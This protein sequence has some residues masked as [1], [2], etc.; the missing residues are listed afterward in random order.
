[1]ESDLSFA[2]K[3]PYLSRDLSENPCIKSEIPTMIPSQLGSTISLPPSH[4]TT[5]LYQN[6]CNQFKEHP[7]NEANHHSS[8]P[9][10]A[11]SSISP[12]PMI[13]TPLYKVAH[14]NGSQREFLNSQNPMIFAP[15]YNKMEVMHGRLNSGKGIWDLSTKNLFHYGETSQPR[16][17]PDIIKG[18]WT[19]NEDRVLVQ[20]VNH[21]GLRKWSHIAKYMK[22]RIGKQCRE[23]WNNH[24]RPDIKKDSWTEEEDKILIKAHKT[25]GNK[26]AEISKRL[27]GR[28]ENSIKNH[29][30]AT[31]RRQNAKRKN[32]GNSSKGIL[33]L[34]YIMEVTNAKKAEKKLVKNSTSMTN[35][36]NQSNFESSESDFSSKDLA[37]PEEEIDGYVPMMDHHDDGMARGSGTTMSYEFGTYGMEFFHEVPMK[38]EI[39]LMNMI[40][41]NP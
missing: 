39:D 1:M 14:T 5:F 18:Q 40:Y 10:V 12:F 37:N 15:N 32:Q 38:Q 22:G 34:K 2:E 41:K 8:F 36:G 26:W 11:P 30:N 28:T 13:S 25:V 35:I 9:R 24:L 29:W 20:L 19:A 33:L 16:V 27:L 23:R 17:S 3:F 7:L 6:H 4:Y 31:K 21:F